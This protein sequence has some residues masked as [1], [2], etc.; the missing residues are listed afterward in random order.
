MAGVTIQLEQEMQEGIAH[1]PWVNWSAFSREEAAKKA[2]F[3]NYLKTRK[4]TAEEQKFCDEIDWHPVDWLPLKES[5]LKELKKGM[6]GRHSKPMSA[7]EFKKWCER[8]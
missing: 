5:Y 1:L 4:L 2:I 8:L 7:E 3:E 6:K